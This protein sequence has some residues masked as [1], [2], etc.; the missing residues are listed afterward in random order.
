MIVD[1]AEYGGY[2]NST[3]TIRFPYADNIKRYGRHLRSDPHFVSIASTYMVGRNRDD[4][5]QQIYGP[6]GFKFTGFDEV[7]NPD[8]LDILVFYEEKDCARPGR[9]I[10]EL[11]KHGGDLPQDQWWEVFNLTTAADGITNEGQTNALCEFKLECIPY[12]AALPGVHLGNF[13]YD[14]ARSVQTYT[15]PI[16]G[17]EKNQQ[18][19]FNI[20]NYYQGENDCANPLAHSGHGT[21]S[22]CSTNTT[23][24][25]ELTFDHNKGKNYFNSPQNKVNMR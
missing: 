25:N 16:Y 3:C 19:T 17:L 24:S 18:A 7:S 20:L 13:N 4:F 8:A 15:V 14:I 1:P 2:I 23:C 12:G 6:D 5:S 9:D 11:P 21:A 10:S 22:G